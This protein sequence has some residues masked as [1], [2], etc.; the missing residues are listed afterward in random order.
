M[1][2]RARERIILAHRTND[3][4]DFTIELF[5]DYKIEDGEWIGVCTQ[6]GVAANA[7][8]LDEAKEI[9]KDL[10]LLQLSGMEGLTNIYDYLEENE[11]AILRP[12]RS[13]AGDSGFVL[14]TAAAGL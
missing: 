11:V 9:L 10:V 1:T 6:L 2:A 8:K 3:S 5:L 13:T 7:E 14:T 4:Q 12:E